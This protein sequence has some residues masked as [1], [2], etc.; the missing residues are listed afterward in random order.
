MATITKYK[1][2]LDVAPDFKLRH[3]CACCHEFIYEDEAFFE[4]DAFFMHEEC[5]KC[6]FTE[7]TLAELFGTK[8][9]PEEDY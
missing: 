5:I 7:L 4:F 1:D 8:H 3:R 2:E 6:N 9:D